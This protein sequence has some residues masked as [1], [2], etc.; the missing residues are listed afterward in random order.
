MKRSP[1]LAVPLIALA[2]CTATPAPEAPAPTVTVTAEPTPTPEPVAEDAPES[3]GTLA[4]AMAW[5]S[6]SKSDRESVCQLYR[7]TPNLAWDTFENSDGGGMLTRAE[8]DAFFDKK[9]GA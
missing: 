1:L 5:E 8:F 3:E 7:L 2:A 4:L 6:Q 9:C